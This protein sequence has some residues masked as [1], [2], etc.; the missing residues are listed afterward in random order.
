M[1]NR[2][3]HFIGLVPLI[4]A[5]CL[6]L[7]IS[8]ASA[9]TRLNYNQPATGTLSAGQQAE[10][11]FSGQA[12]DKPII[13]ANAHGGDI[14]PYVA[15]YDPAGH[16]IGE[17]INGGLKG[18][19]LLKGQVL[20]ADGTY[21]VVV[22]NKAQNGSGN[23]NLLISEEQRQVFFDGPATGT[24]GKQAYQLSQP[25]DHSN[26]TYHILN[27]LPQFSEQET[28][29][30]FAQ[31]FQSWASLSTLRFTEVAGQG[32][33]NIQFG[34]IDGQ[35]NILGETCPPYQ[36]CDSGSVTFDS[37]ENWTLGQPTGF[38][39]ISL[40][41]V[42]SHEF[43]HAIGMLHTDDQNAL[44]FPEYS[45][46]VLAPS[47]DDAAGVAR[48]YG[49]GNGTVSNPPVGSNPPSTNP[50][51]MQVTDS[52]DNSHYTTFW[53]FD[54]VAGDTA[55]I[56]MS[57]TQGDLDSFLVLLDANNQVIA[58]D[59]DSGGGRNAAL[60]NLKF[61]YAGTY[62]VAA[63]RYLQAQGYTAGSYRLSIQY[64]V[65]AGQNTVPAT[66]VASAPPVSGTGG[67]QASAGQPSQLQQLPSLDSVL[68]S[69]FADSASPGKQTRQGTVSAGQSY[70]WQQ[71]WCATNSPTLAAN[72]QQISATFAING[73]P[74]SPSAVSQTSAA[75]A[76]YQCQ[77]FFVVLSNWT[78]G[79]V[80]LTTTLTLRGAVFDGETI[81]PAG[82]YVTEYQLQ[83]SG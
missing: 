67:V 30:M 63:T 31:A 74:V 1:K 18:N 46:Y 10:Y 29:A 15:L 20:A 52:L 8:P 35:L 66:T 37:D 25:W 36:P 79:S 47:Q 55:T 3:Q 28:R 72:L 42:A 41:G 80:T 68:T 60:A 82:D 34:Q 78:R 21:K 76:P 11:T 24:G 73:Q 69:A 71:N 56:T 70:S 22:A 44:M 38:G 19:A 53:D 17:D 43:G 58:Y 51:Q 57:A 61:P 50:N 5:L 65:G 6:L 49:P 48:L 75:N 77:V 27:K 39:D 83:A 14:V 12:G 7:P 45:P 16:L 33:I 81:Y 59:D 9:A 26:I 13:R 4:V 64:D 2:S 23:Y 40:L 62:T 54:V 32:D